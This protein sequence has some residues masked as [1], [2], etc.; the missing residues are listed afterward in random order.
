MVTIFT[1]VNIIRFNF[2]EKK[3]ISRCLLL[4]CPSHFIRRKK[5][6]T[7]HWRAAWCCNVPQYVYDSVSNVSHLPAVNNRVQRWIQKYKNRWEEIKSLKSNSRSTNSNT[8]YIGNKR[9]I[10]NQKYKVHVIDTNRSPDKACQIC[11]FTNPL[12]L[13]FMRFLYLQGLYLILV[14]S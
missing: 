11:H 7:H 3:F 1:K 13:F 10:A 2:T 14:A 9:Q 8:N 4:N 5:L 6:W 12:N